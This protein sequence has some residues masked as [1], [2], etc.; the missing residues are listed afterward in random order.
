MS[1][2]DPEPPARP[3]RSLWLLLT[4]AVAVALGMGLGPALLFVTL[5]GPPAAVTTH[6]RP[7]LVPSA[8][9][10]SSPAG[11]ADGRRI[12]CTSGSFTVTGRASA[13]SG[14]PR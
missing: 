11:S 4:A 2:P 8:D 7:S 6:P 3:A 5:S 9:R 13:R 12:T 1:H 14:Q 10:P